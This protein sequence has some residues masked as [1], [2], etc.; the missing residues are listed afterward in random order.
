M[1]WFGLD[2]LVQDMDQW[3]D[4]CEEGNDALGYTICWEILE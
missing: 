4:S 1:G 2:H 3:G